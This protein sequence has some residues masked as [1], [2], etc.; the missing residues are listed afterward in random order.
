MI[1]HFSILFVI[2]FA[3]IIWGRQIRLVKLSRLSD[4]KDPASYKGSVWP[5]FLV[6]GY[7]AFLAGMRTGMNDTSVYVE[8]FKA[9]EGSWAE[10]QRIFYSDEKD[11][12][13]YMLQSVFKLYVGDHYHLWFLFVAALESAALIYLLR[14]ESVDFA[15]ACFFFFANTLYYNYFSMMRQWLAVVMLFCGSLLIKNRRPIL[16]ILLCVLMAQFHTSAYLMIP[17]YFLVTGRPWSLVQILTIIAFTIAIIALNPLLETLGNTLEGTTYDYVVDTMQTG[18]GSSAIRILV[19]LVPVWLAW[20]DRHRTP[21]RMVQIAVNMSLINLLL[22]IL[23]TFTSGLYVIRLSTYTSIYNVILYP[24][25][26]HVSLQG[27]NRQLVKA[28]FYILFFLYY[29]YAMKHQG[30][31]GYSSD[32]LGKFT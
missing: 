8:T 32:I 5:W 19:A 25:L 15:S 28:L 31:F 30:A 9:A 23:A 16:Y 21:P 29:F 26:L 24:Y 7:I 11:K 12:A 22:N 20:M 14:R 10:V 17:V 6:F 3:N 1:I 27:R 4:G 2:L 13:F 18:T